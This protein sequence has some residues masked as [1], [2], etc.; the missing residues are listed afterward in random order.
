MPKL[1]YLNLE[2]SIIMAYSGTEGT[3]ESSE[4]TYYANEIPPYAFNAFDF[5]TTLSKENLISI[6]MPSSTISI[7]A[8]AFYNRYSMKGQLIIP[9]TVTNIGNF[10]F[11]NC[12]GLNGN[13][14][15][16]NNVTSI[17]IKAFRDCDGFNGTLTLSNSLETIGD[18]A[19]CSC[20]ALKGTLN[21][22]TTLKSIGRLGFCACKALTGTLRLN[23]NLVNI[24]PYAFSGCTGFTG[25]LSIPNSVTTIGEYAFNECTGFNGTLTIPASVTSI[26]RAAFWNCNRFTGSLII[27]SSIKSIEESTFWGCSGFDGNLTI[28]SSVSNIKKFAFYNCN[29]LKGTLLIPSSVKTIAEHAFRECRGFNTLSLPDSIKSIENNVF[30]NCTGFR[31]PLTIPS[32]LTTISPYL[33]AGCGFDG[34]LIIPETITTISSGAFSDCSKLSGTLNIPSSVTSISYYAFQ[35]CSGF[36]GSLVIPKSIE[37]IYEN[38]FYNCTGFSG[39]LNIPE[40]IKQIDRLAFYNCTGLSGTLTIPKSVTTISSNTFYNCTGLNDKLILY[41]NLTYIGDQA[42]GNCV[43]I[44]EI[45]IYRTHP[46]YISLGYRVFIGMKTSDCILHVPPTSKDLYTGAAQWKEFTSVLND[47]RIQLDAT[48]PTVVINKMVDGKTNAAITKTGSLTGVSNGDWFY[49]TLNASASYEDANVGI[50]KKIV[51]TYTLSGDVAVNYLAPQDYVINNGKISDFITI[52]SITSP[53]VVCGNSFVELKYIINTGT[54]THYKITFGSSALNEG[55]NNI[56]YTAIPSSN[57]KNNIIIPIPAGIK[58]GIYYGN[59]KLKN[60]LNV[61][62]SNYPFQFSVDVSAEKLVTKFDDIILFNNFE[63]R[64]T[65]YQWYKNGV[66]ISGA[67]KQFYCDPNGLNGDYSVRLITTTGDTLYSCVKTL[68]LRSNNKSID[69]PNPVK[70]NQNFTISLTN[71]NNND[72]KDATISIYNIQ[73]ECIYTTNSV[74]MENLIQLNR[75]GIYLIYIDS[76]NQKVT[77]KILVT[78]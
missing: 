54:P 40:S 36:T 56:Q 34:N 57:E 1:A 69:F 44:K 26:G 68:H 23:N 63:N 48:P 33:F 3:N 19:F 52:K 55:L 45:D 11:Y 37:R 27:P 42:F 13:L 21:I 25:S 12:F 47:L 61:E 17:G 7:G 73:G 8:Y 41:N 39:I 62:S 2:S 29:K 30:Q 78:Q 20:D 65:D 5:S 38:T 9:E 49:V 64:F 50:N 22:P 31:G 51:V 4:T 58:D 46:E 15:I 14:V 24:G 53:E 77:S 16:P 43:N 71:W 28:P 6:K 35:N 70:K 18:E 66:E 59:I 72:L 67:T 32:S 60:E 76:K 10:A 75:A 74:F